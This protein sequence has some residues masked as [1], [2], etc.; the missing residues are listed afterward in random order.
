MQTRQALI[1][2]HSVSGWT[3]SLSLRDGPSRTV[4]A[5]CR[6]EPLSSIGEC[7]VRR[8]EGVGD[9]RRTAGREDRSASFSPLASPRDKARSLAAS[10]VGADGREF[11]QPPGVKRWKVLTALHQRPLRESAPEL[12]LPVAS[13]GQLDIVF[14]YT[15]V[16]A[17]ARADIK[18]RIRTLAAR[19]TSTLTPARLPAICP[20]DSRSRA[21]FDRVDRPSDNTC[22]VT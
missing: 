22:A 18:A 5:S 7:T 17:H 20:D 14:T 2:I 6:K 1:D 11:R 3:A 4:V 21:R 19:S 16:Q 10:F 15:H 8:L 12:S 13:S 9:Q